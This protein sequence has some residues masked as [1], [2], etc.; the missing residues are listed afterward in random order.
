MSGAYF[1]SFYVK[2]TDAD[3]NEKIEFNLTVTSCT[4]YHAELFMIYFYNTLWWL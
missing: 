4:G 3:G 1:I 2:F